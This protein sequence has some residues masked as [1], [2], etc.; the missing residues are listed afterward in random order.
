[1]E[2]LPPAGTT[3]HGQAASALPLPLRP[4]GGTGALRQL[5]ASPQLTS[6]LG[7]IWYKVEGTPSC[8]CRMT[9]MTFWACHQGVVEVP[10]S[11]TP[12]GQPTLALPPP[13]LLTD[14]A[15]GL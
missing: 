3:W 15:S 10:T 11:H 2:L 14:G 7:L 8:S 4:C 9:E 1:M 13:A 12:G 6:C 5:P